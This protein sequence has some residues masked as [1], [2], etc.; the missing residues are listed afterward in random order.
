MEQSQD[1][2]VVFAV[3]EFVE[4][5][6]AAGH[7]LTKRQLQNDFSLFDSRIAASHVNCWLSLK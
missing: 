1:V 3:P 2:P 7:I 5:F 6:H 4:D